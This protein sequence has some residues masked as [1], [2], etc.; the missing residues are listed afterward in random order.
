MAISVTHSTAVVVPDDGSSPVGSDEW[1]AAHTF[2][3]ATSRLLGRTTADAGPSEE[4]EVG[5]GLSLTAGVLSNT[6]TSPVIAVVKTDITTRVN[7]TT[8]VADP[9]LVSPTLPA[10]AY[11]QFWMVLLHSAHATPDL[12]L[13]I[14]KL[15]GLDD[16]TLRYSF[17]LDN[18][19]VNPATWNTQVNVVGANALRMGHY[20]GLLYTGTVGG[21]LE[22]RWAQQTLDAVNTSSLLQSS[23]ILLT[24]LA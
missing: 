9:H 19:S 11:Y 13:Q 14:S 1:N 3:M 2:T 24:R 15:S 18:R 8:R 5:T 4:I 16:A 6:V 22:L 17:D 12:A 10:L 7:T 20:S 23:C 21:V